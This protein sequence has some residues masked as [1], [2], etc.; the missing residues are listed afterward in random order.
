MIS[1]LDISN[2][3][4]TRERIL[5]EEKSLG[6]ESRRRRIDIKRQCDWK[7]KR[8]EERTM[9]YVFKKSQGGDSNEPI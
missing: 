6:P 5:R 7:R 4:A 8:R 3:V 9:L 2:A 1:S